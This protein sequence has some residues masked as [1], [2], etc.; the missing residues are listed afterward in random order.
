MRRWLLLLVVALCA[1]ACSDGEPDGPSASLTTPPSTEAPTVEDEVEAAYLRSWEV[2]AEAMLE[3]DPGGLDRA[4]AKKAL[5]LRIGEVAALKARG[6]PA[7]M[8]VDHQIAEVWLRESAAYV[9]DNYTNHSVLLDPRTKEP[10]EPDPN[11][12]ESRTYTLER[13]EGTWRVTFVLDKSP[14]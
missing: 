11:T 9:T 4:F 8:E 13:I 2:Y 7:R 14:R 1:V 3:L 6:T 10:T 5:E 12:S